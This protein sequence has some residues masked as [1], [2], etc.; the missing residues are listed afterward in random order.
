MHEHEF[1]FQHP[2]WSPEHCQKWSLILELGVHPEHSQVW[3]QHT[4]PFKKNGWDDD[5]KDAESPVS[6]RYD[7]RAFI[8]TYITVIDS[9]RILQMLPQAWGHSFKWTQIT[10]YSACLLVLI[11]KHGS[12]SFY[13]DCPD[14]HFL[15]WCSWSE[16]PQTSAPWLFRIW[17]FLYILTSYTLGKCAALPLYLPLISI[18]FTAGLTS[19]QSLS[20]TIW[21]WYAAHNLQ[22]VSFIRYPA[23]DHW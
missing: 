18:G 16:F 1:N 23:H 12:F 19:Y 20:G 9:S 6:L 4:P 3:P 14:A 8:W 13:L 21:Y 22:N 15:S 10:S 11:L 2:I 5:G 7:P 17:L